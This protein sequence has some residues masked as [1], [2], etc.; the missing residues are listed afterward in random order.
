MKQ[1]SKRAAIIAFSYGLLCA[2]LYSLA[3]TTYTDTVAGVGT[4]EQISGPS[5]VAHFI[6]EFG[7]F[8]W[9]SSLLPIW[10]FMF[11]VIYSSSIILA[12]WLRKKI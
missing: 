4:I 11:F 9:F 7:F 10:G 12:I 5:A 8:N 3:M 1:I 2:F 6:S